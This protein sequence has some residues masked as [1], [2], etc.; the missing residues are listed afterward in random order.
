MPHRLTGNERYIGHM[1]LRHRFGLRIPE[2]FVISIVGAGQRRSH[3][4]PNH[5]IER[6]PVSYNKGNDAISDLKF[7]IRYEPLEL[8]L[9]KAAFKAIGPERLEDWVRWEPSG[10]FARRA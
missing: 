6:Y 2:P 5:Q 8:G 3:S 7:A 1:G 10:Q 9:L 4:Q